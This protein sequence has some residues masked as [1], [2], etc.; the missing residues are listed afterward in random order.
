MVHVQI[1][2][3]D[4]ISIIILVLSYLVWI[5]EK[6]GKKTNKCFPVV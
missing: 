4:D 6:R 1:I 2:N 5:E 3:N